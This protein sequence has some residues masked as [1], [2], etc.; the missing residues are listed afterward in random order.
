ML[1]LL[2]PQNFNIQGLSLEKKNIVSL[3]E[4]FKTR[5]LEIPFV[6]R[7]HCFDYVH[8]LLLC[9]RKLL[10]ISYRPITRLV[11]GMQLPLS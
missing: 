3:K 5:R 10:D 8:W 9:Y 2:H 7:T 6:E 11:R 4:S 1:N